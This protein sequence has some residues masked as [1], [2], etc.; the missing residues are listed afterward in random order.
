MPGLTGLRGIAVAAVVAYHLG[1]LPG[2]FLGVD[3]FF[4]LSGFLITTLLLRRPPELPHG[5]ARWWL[6]R[7]TRLTP[8][9]VVVVI[10]VLVAFA[11]RSGVVLDGVATVTWWQNWH[12]ILDGQSYWAGSPSP[13]RHAWSLSIEEQFYVL[14]PISLIGL[15][16][17]ARRR[18]MN[19]S[20]LV[21]VVAAVVSGASFA[22][23]GVLAATGDVD[24]SRIYFG[25]D[26]RAGALLLGCAM[27]SARVSRRRA[28]T[29]ARQGSDQRVVPTSATA[30][31]L[32]AA[33][34]LVVLASVATPEDRWV[35]LGGLLLAAGCSSVLILVAS[36][37]G[38]METVLQQPVLQWLGVRSYAVY[39]WSWPLQVFLEGQ[40]VSGL[41][42]TAVTVAGSLALAH[43][44]LRLVEEPLRRGSGWARRFRPR[45]VAWGAGAAA[46]GVALLFAA[47]STEPTAGELVSQEF[48]RLPDPVQAS[49]TTT[50]CTPLPPTA[51]TPTF[52]D[53]TTGFDEATVQQPTDPSGVPYCDDAVTKVLVVGDSTGRGAVNGL[54]RLAA[55]DLEVWDRVELGCGLTADPDCADWRTL[56][57]GAVRQIQPEVVLAYMR[58]TDDLVPGDDPEFTSSEA[59]DLRRSLMRE[60]TGILGAEGAQVIW[61]LPAAPLPRGAF[62][63]RGEGEGTP[64]D[65]A[66]VQ[67]WRDD[68]AAVAAETGVTTIDVQAWVDERDATLDTDRPDGLHLSGPALDE[69]ARW[70]ADRLRSA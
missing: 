16:G 56:W 23:A 68:L 21:T 63:C 5:L 29:D 47:S 64:C 19:P 18:R 11:T 50:T 32:G 49:T 42:L 43:V 52:T 55:A 4:V 51:P 59:S 25:T 9:V 58:T 34:V 15:V 13:L 36:R 69:H 6:R 38:P 46:L 2:G 53:D 10:V 24:L 67:L 7:F 8:A 17:L 65:P 60:A 31:A 12:L 20:A 45:R 39:L 66:W 40:G 44:S 35:Y 27:A 14:W 22:W 70:L 1:H 28:G 54:R 26:T 57:S 41:A 61:A 37:P 33:L 62:Y 48:E 30:A 3:L